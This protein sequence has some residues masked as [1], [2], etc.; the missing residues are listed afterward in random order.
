MALRIVGA[1]PSYGFE[2]VLSQAARII[3][4]EL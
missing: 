3:R 4:L 2:W 1:G